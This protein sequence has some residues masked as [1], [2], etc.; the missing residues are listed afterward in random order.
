MS[1]R[2]L[3]VLV[4]IAALAVVTA[5]CAQPPP[6]SA[7]KDPVIIVG[8]TFVGQPVAEIY[9]APLATRL[10]NDGYRVTIWGIPNAGFGDIGTSAGSLAAAVDSVRTQ[11]GSAKVD[12]IGHSQGGLVSRHFVKYL[13]G[14]AKVDSLISL[15]AP[16]YGSAGANLATL[17]GLGSCLG[18]VACQQMSI[19][20]SYLADL[21]AGP[22]QIGSVRYTNIVTAFDEF[23]V[24]Y[25]NGFLANDTANNK[26]V[27]V[28]SQCPLRILGH[29]LLATDGTVYS[30]I[31]DALAHHSISLECLVL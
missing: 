20:S 15:G 19:G 9:Y 28:Q 29:I 4:T 30:G 22:D 17:F 13:G 27:S 6:S 31:L 5:S 16:H 10:R 21:N 3:R 8:G 24:P 1:R 11:T 26:N 7:P 14:D 23:V 18:V 12:L 25:T 2:S